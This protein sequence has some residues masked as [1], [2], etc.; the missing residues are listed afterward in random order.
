MTKIQNSGAFDKRG[1]VLKIGIRFLEFVCLLDIV[2]W[3]LTLYLAP[4]TLYLVPCT[5]YL[6]PCTLYLIPNTLKLL[7]RLDRLSI[8]KRRLMILVAALRHNMQKKKDII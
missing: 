5:L 6:S 4:C 3:N 2:I 7:K 8:R 1:V